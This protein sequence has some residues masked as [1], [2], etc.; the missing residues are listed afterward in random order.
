MKKRRQGNK[1]LPV[2]AAV[3]IQLKK[4]KARLPPPEKVLNI[5]K[6]ISKG[7]Q[8]LLSIRNV[9]FLGIVTDIVKRVIYRKTA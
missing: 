5:S 7:K 4:I 8:K 2:F 9:S 6:G 3:L 1:Q